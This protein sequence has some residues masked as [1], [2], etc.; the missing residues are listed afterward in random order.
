MNRQN[1]EIDPTSHNGGHTLERAFWPIL[2]H[3]IFYFSK[4]QTLKFE[5]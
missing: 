1:D 4:I 5:I 2:S 3:F